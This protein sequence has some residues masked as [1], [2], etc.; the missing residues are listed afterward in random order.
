MGGG[1][2]PTPKPKGSNMTTQTEI[3]QYRLCRHTKADGSRCHAA[4][5]TEAAFCF[6]HDRLHKTPRPSRHVGGTISLSGP[7]IELN[8]LEDR[9]SIQTALG[10]VIN[11]LATGYLDLK[12]ARVLLYGIQMATINL[13][14]MNA[15][16]AEMGGSDDDDP[17]NDLAE[18]TPFHPVED[19]Q[20]DRA[21]DQAITVAFTG[22]NR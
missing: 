8:G 19:L 17:Y 6:F 5:M 16:A 2:P 3:L 20:R 7:E 14:Q 22:K 12:R 21:M 18:I 4:A 11:S 9:A 1:I 15:D 10:I 13:K